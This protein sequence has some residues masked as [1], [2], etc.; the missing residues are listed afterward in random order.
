MEE[1]VKEA[2]SNRQLVR[3][4]GRTAGVFYASSIQE[5]YDAVTKITAIG[6]RYN[7]EIVK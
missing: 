5:Y 3:I 6:A 2:F 4:D 7:I 1:L